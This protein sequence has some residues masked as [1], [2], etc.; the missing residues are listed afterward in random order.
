MIGVLTGRQIDRIR[1]DLFG[2]LVNK[3]HEMQS[4]KL[5]EIVARAVH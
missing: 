1:E 5:V 3:T 2:L 4:H